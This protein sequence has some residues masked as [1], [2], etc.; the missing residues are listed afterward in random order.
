QGGVSHMQGMMPHQGLGQQMVHPTPG[1]GAQMQGQW[2][3][4]LGA[5]LGQILMAG[6]RGAVPQSG[7]PQVSSVMEDEIL[8]DLI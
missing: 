7:M 3:Q 4:P 2:R 6:Q 8:M 1:G 5:C